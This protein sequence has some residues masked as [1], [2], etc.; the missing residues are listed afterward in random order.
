MFCGIA[1]E[2]LPILFCVWKFLLL[3]KSKFLL[4]EENGSKKK[5]TTKIM[6]TNRHLQ[7]IDVCFF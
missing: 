3:K 5:T 2:N 4:F 6:G 7:T 1:M